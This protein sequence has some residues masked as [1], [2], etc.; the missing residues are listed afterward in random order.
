MVWEEHCWFSRNSGWRRR[1]RRSC[2][3]LVDGSPAKGRL[4]A[5]H[6][7]GDAPWAAAACRLRLLLPPPPRPAVAWRQRRCS[8][9]VPRGGLPI[10]RADAARRGQPRLQ[11][12][13]AVLP[14]RLQLGCTGPRRG[15]PQRPG[16]ALLPRRLPLHKVVAPGAAYRARRVR[17][18]LR[19]LL[20][21]CGG[22]E[23]QRGRPRP[24]L[25]RSQ[26]KGVVRVQHQGWDGHLARLPGALLQLL[27]CT[28]RK[29][30]AQTLR[31]LAW[32]G[33]QA[34]HEPQAGRVGGTAAH[35]G[36]S[37]CAAR[38]SAEKSRR[39]GRW[40]AHSRA[41]S[42]CSRRRCAARSSSMRR[43]MAARYLSASSS[44]SSSTPTTATAQQAAAGRR[45]E[46]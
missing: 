41:A 43:R 8:C 45:I 5:V 10:K 27:D 37:C 46:V 25:Q 12:L 4:L 20:H 30:K 16:A 15:L 24:R 17:L 3:R 26:A 1:R 42:R 22:A 39:R 28:G 6:H 33:T 31:G 36:H 11:V 32:Q 44:S 14:Q 38:C 21:C 40:W 23:L 34:A 2:C 13:A 9:A 29:Q 18:L 35:G 7:D 19:L